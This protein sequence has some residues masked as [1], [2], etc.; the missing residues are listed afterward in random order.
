MH[1]WLALISI[2]NFGHYLLRGIESAGRD[3]GES[4]LYAARQPCFQGTRLLSRLNKP[5]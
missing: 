3:S 1:E 4:Q 5:W 2:E